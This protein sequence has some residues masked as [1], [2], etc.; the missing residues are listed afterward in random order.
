MAAG[1]PKDISRGGLHN[2]RL[3]VAPAAHNFSARYVKA[4]YDGVRP[5]RGTGRAEGVEREARSAAGCAAAPAMGGRWVV[6][7]AR[8]SLGVLSLNRGGITRS[9][10][11]R[12]SL[13]SF[14]H[15]SIHISRQSSD[16]EK[17]TREKIRLG[18]FK[19]SEESTS[20]L[21]RHAKLQRPRLRYRADQRRIR[22]RTGAHQPGAGWG[23]PLIPGGWTGVDE[24]A[25]G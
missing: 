24:T 18:H 19:H 15:I 22:L 20:K 23:D 17:C 25:G 12:G 7:L 1:P 14:L 11:H 4:G 16:P 8:D 6:L 10:L 5:S 3:C 21:R 13:R 2:V 9:Q